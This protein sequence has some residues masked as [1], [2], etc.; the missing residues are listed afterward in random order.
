MENLGT[1]VLAVGALGTAA[2]G[3]VEALK[4]TSLGLLG[5]SRIGRLLGEPVMAALGVAYGPDYLALLRAQYRAGRRDASLASTL[6]QGARVGLTP[7]TAA[8]MARAVG[9]VAEQDLREVATALAQGEEL[10][11]AQRGILGR[12]ELALDARI[13]AALSLAADR[14]AG[15]LRV[16][17]SLVAITIALAVGL[18]RGQDLVLSLI[19]GVAAVPI[20]PMAKDLSSAIKAAGRALP[21]KS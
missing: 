10:S 4:W 20:A 5:F 15:S 17:A 8:G 18:S 9:V 19:V 1:L 13:D 6:R 2:F 3:I 16:A 21:G 7:E 12:F 14:Y 11:A